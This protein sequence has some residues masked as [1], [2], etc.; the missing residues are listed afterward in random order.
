MSL[1]LVIMSRLLGCTPSTSAPVPVDT[2][3]GQADAGDTASAAVD[4]GDQDT[5]EAP[6]AL[7]VVFEPEPARTADNPL[8]GFYTNYAWGDPV[9][10]FPDSLEFAYIPLRDLMDGPSQFTFDTGLEPR[11]IEAEA[12]GHQLI[13]RP[14]IDYPAHPSGLPDFLSGTVAMQAY[15]DH[16]GGLSPDYSDPNLRAAMLAFVEALGAEYDGDPRLALVQAGL[17]GFWGEWHT[18]PH[19]EWFPESGFQADILAAYTTAFDETL[20]QVR[21]PVAQSPDIRFGFHDDSF[22]YSTIG[23][24]DWFF[25]PMLEAA[26]ADERWREVPIGGELRPE[27]QWWIFEDGYTTDDPY[28]QDFDECVEATHASM[29]LNFAAF[30]GGLE[31]QDERERGEAAALSLGYSLHVARADVTDDVLTAQVENRGSAPFYYPLELRVFDEDGSVRT[32]SMPRFARE[33]GPVEITVD[34]AGLSQ[35]TD[36]APWTLGLHSDHVLPSQTVRFATA[37]GDGPL[38]VQ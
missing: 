17:L 27:L 1:F 19:T 24:I 10:P 25:H 21:Y 6:L 8:R 36:A 31:T 7:S 12:R 14:Y 32:A 33:D 5:A 23:D 35:P 11:L 9:S 37:P 28:R 4:T 38:Q 26:G 2:D 18:W 16:G 29:L 15:T 20:L 22:A 3:A 34:V 30:G 13:L